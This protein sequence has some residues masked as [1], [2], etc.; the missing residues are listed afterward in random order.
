MEKLNQKGW[1]RRKRKIYTKFKCWLVE[2]NELAEES[3]F[4]DCFEPNWV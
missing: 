1:P 4:A 2:R 3:P